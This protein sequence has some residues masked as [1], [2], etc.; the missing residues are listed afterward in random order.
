MRKVTISGLVLAA[1]AAA[2][3]TLLPA[4]AGAQTGTLA[5]EGKRFTEPYALEIEGE[6]DFNAVINEDDSKLYNFM[7]GPSIGVF[8]VKGLQ[9]GGVPTLWFIIE[10]D[11]DGDQTTILAGG[12]TIFMRYVFDTNTIV[13]PF[14]G[15]RF[16]AFG[17]TIDF[18]T[19]VGNVERT[20]NIINVGPEVGIKIAFHRAVATIFF[21]YLFNTTGIEDIDDREN[22]HDIR[23]GVGFGLWI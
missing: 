9:I 21:R 3:L 23:L 7:L 8:V 2:A 20:I 10:E 22:S 18:D 12:L 4:A 11:G 17:G 16:G 13:F 6:F 5:L 15:V 14:L 19:G 1:S